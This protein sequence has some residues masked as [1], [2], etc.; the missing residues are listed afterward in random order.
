MYVSCIYVC[1]NFAT[2]VQDTSVNEGQD[3]AKYQGGDEACIALLT[4]NTST[5]TGVT[6]PPDDELTQVYIC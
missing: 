3:V 6:T 1:M 4:T 5:E 2:G